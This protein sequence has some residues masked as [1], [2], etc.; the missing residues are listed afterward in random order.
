MRDIFNSSTSLSVAVLGMTLVV[1]PFPAWAQ[2]TSDPEQSDGGPTEI[3]VTAQKR[4]QLLSDVG[5]TISAVGQE[6]IVNAGVTNVAALSKIVPGLSVGA[7]FD[8]L[9][10]FSIRGI[11]FNSNQLGGAPTV[12]TYMDQAPLPF[13]AMTAGQILDLER[14]EVLKGPQGTLFGQNS[15]GGAINFIPARPTDYLSAGIRTSLDNFGQLSGEGF[16]S[17]PLG[18]N[19][20]ARV[21]VSTAQGGDW[22]KAYTYKNKIGSA[23]KA[24]AR[25]LL[26][27]KASDSLKVSLNLNG[28]FDKS[29]TQQQY[30]LKPFP[31]QPTNPAPGLIGY[32]LPPRDNRA[33]DFDASPSR[34]FRFDNKFGQA[35]LRADYD[36]AE[37][38]TLT[39]LTSIASMDYSSFRDTDAT[40]IPIINGGNKGKL[41]SFSQEIRLS[42]S[43]AA[44]ALEYILGANFSNDRVNE[45]QPQDFIR[46]SG[47]PA[48]LKLGSFGNFRSKTY[49]LFGNIEWKFADQLT[50][51]AGARRT[52]VKQNYTSCLRDTGDG[53]LASFI[54]GIAN[55]FRSSGTPS[56]PPTSAYVAGGCAT[57]G[58][59]PNFE[60]FLY[61]P[62]SV[63]HNTSW[64]IGLNWKPDRD[65]LVYALVSR[66]FKAGA[67][68]FQNSIS[69]EQYQ[70]VAQEK[71]TSYEVGAKYSLGSK[72]SI[73]ASAFYYDY[74]NLQTYAIKHVPVVGQ[75]SALENIPTSTAY[76]FDAE[77]VARPVDGLTLRS[78]ATYSHTKLGSFITDNVLGVATNVKG[79]PFTY[80]PR[81][82]ITGDAEYAVPLQGKVEG[83]AGLSWL[84]HSHS[85]GALTHDPELALPS[86]LTLDAR[87]GV[88]SSAGWNAQLWVRNLTDK[89]FLVSSSVAGDALAGTTGM[90]RT[91]GL[92]VGYSF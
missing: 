31:G 17:G 54:G 61:T 1:V 69:V 43:T 57:I 60:P 27:W 42:G 84:Y 64:K 63:D 46:Y 11:S 21:A 91:F 87:L 78:A 25:Q 45:T 83:Y 22:Q 85:S 53:Q 13:S 70:K 10:V 77:I 52:R 47:I 37:H 19:V 86:Y 33:A 65:T 81:W 14:I 29:D 41:N 35:V 26:D 51:I 20:N 24:S 80:A 4:A 15:T 88:K 44:N 82:T 76:G 28:N 16:V 62:T 90:P 56:L 9:P 68:P 55:F 36:V 30:L 38:A 6:A 5:L 3:I 67:Y 34:P 39:S 72:I 66:G 18:A 12:S 50:L 79:L 49:A 8:G 40:A 7:S 2:A 74:A 73:S 92:T 32:P 23:N 75:I 89:F 58:P 48:G 59:A 71:L